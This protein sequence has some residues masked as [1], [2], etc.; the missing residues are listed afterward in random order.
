MPR[1]FD[2]IE[3]GLLPALRDTLKVSN[4]SDF[5]VGYFNL[6]GWKAIDDLIARWPGGEGSCCRL[7]V[8]MQRL[9][10]DELRSA[11]GV[12]NDEPALDNQTAIRLK[13]KLAEEF[14]AQL[15]LGMPSNEDEAGLRR[16]AEQLRSGKVVVKLFLRHTLHAKLYLMFRSDPN[17]P[18]TGFLGSSNL[19][20]SGLSKQGELN[21]D[22]L[23]HDATNKLAN[24]FE[25]RWEDR[26]CI[27]ITTDLIEVIEESWA[28]EDLIDPYLIYVK[29][30]YHL[31][32]EARSGLSEFRIPREF[33]KK[34]FP[35][36]EAAVK[37]SAHHLQKRGGVLIGD[38]VGLGKTL[39]ATAVAK[40]FQD[41]HS[42]ETLIICPKNLVKMWEG[43]VEEY[44]LIAKVL[45]V[46]RAVRELPNLRRFRLVLIDESHNLRNRE[47]QRY[48]AIQEYLAENESRCILLSATPYNKTYIDL[49]SQLR[50]FVPEDHDLGIRP[51]R[52]LS[53]IGET[54]FIRRHQCSVRSLAA[55][56]KSEFPDDWRELMRLYMVRRTRTFIQ[57][58]YATTDPEN[59]RRYL[60]FEDGTRSY[61]PERLPRT[62]KFKISDEDATD[63]YAGLYA[64]SVVDAIN[65]MHLPRYGL[66]NYVAPA[67]DSPPTP[68]ED[69]QL[70]DLSRAGKRLMGFCRTNLFKR[71]E[72]SG[73]AFQQSI[74]RHVLRNYVFLHAI[75][76]ELPLPLGTQDA[77]LLDTANYDEDI[78]D[79]SADAEIVAESEDDLF[80]AAQEPNLRDIPSFQRRAADAYELYSGRFKKRFK[81]L[82]P[83][84]FISD[85]RLHLLEDSA[86]LMKILND[87][88]PWKAS[89]DRKLEA[90][91][92][93]L[94]VTHP[95]EKVMIFSQFADTVRYLERQ[96]K[97][98][99]L[100]A[101]AGVTGE[102]D[103]PTSFAWRF[104]PVSN[105]KRA[106]VKIEDELRVLIATDVLSEGQNLQDCSI[107][108]NFDLPWA[109][110]RLIQRAGRVD[111]IGQKAAEILCYSFL[112]ADGVE[113]LINLRSR[114]SQRLRENAEVVGTDESFF[115]DE[116][117]SGALIDLYSEKSG[118]L[119]G[120]ADTEVDL[121]S[122][123][124][125]IWRNAIESNPSLARQI[126]S[127]P[128]VVYST[129]AYLPSPSRPGGALVYM[130]TAQ[131]DDALTWVDQVGEAVT[132][133]QFEILRAA[134]CEPGT[135]ALPRQDHHHEIVGK[136]VS[137]IAAEEKKVG[138]Q[139]GRPTGAR[140]RTYERLKDYAARVKGE[141]FDTPEL[142]RAVEEIYRFPLRQSATDTLNRQ[143]KLGISDE[144]LADLVL[145]LRE[146]DRLCIVQDEPQADE[147]QIICS[148]GLASMTN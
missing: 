87:C 8:G 133:S 120:E 20:L 103:D 60:T 95:T 143:L 129:K 48:K 67:P 140:F 147:P 122:Y 42:A 19:T 32:Q 2:N 88:G 145:A 93:L 116:E 64:S 43:Y 23:D 74:E 62:V 123:A 27:D 128:D 63:Q 80:Q 33:G 107:L 89:Q 4:R 85:L 6:R 94:K 76:N 144:K 99:G 75:D 119:D 132:Q 24:W 26:W 86:T 135:I 58:N 11:L 50:L 28:R 46:T 148:L 61:F 36:Q 114:V 15:T 105:G 29:M 97:K 40:I 9:P 13:R 1:V 77:G 138:G 96:L 78:D 113:R 134:A 82:R 47:G 104:S 112:P 7:L 18:I 21:V 136:A 59:G 137:H 124:Y 41:D 57:E 81:W 45:S 56:E 35:Y 118:I 126:P 53:G 38:V 65:E 110:I 117:D 142:W 100:E 25:D 70:D 51:E 22:V 125:Q 17:N 111:R 98:K 49:S 90:L 79:Q 83:G 3:S 131:G 44:R 10:E 16:L 55:F 101:V 106:Q 12:A 68:Q 92:S 109:I 130:R 141:L 146:E 127:L 5:C 69:R 102:T 115:E 31:A 72:S 54:E 39:M 66:G 84:L 121:A 139:L 14:R 30:A 34:L 52:L 108:V 91:L 73:E 71:L 37:I